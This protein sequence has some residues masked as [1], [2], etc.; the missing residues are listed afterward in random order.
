VTVDPTAL[1]TARLAL[2]TIAAT[3]PM[4]AGA[5]DTTLTRRTAVSDRYEPRTRCHKHAGD[6]DLD[7]DCGNC[8]TAQTNHDRWE[9]HQAARDAELR[10]ERQD[11]DSTERY[12]ALPS[13]RPPADLDVV[14]VRT[15][16]LQTV[17]TSVLL[18]RSDLAP[19]L[20]R[21]GTT[22]GTPP[23]RVTVSSIYS[24]TR[25]LAD[26]LDHTGGTTAA[27]IGTELRPAVERVHQVLGIDPDSAWRPMGTSR[28]P[29]CRQRAL[30]RWTDSP[31]R[32]AWT[33]ECR[34]P[35]CECAGATCPCGRD[36]ARSGSR[37][38]WQA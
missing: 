11:R 6:P 38:L 34:N 28:C 7:D 24:A 19:W 31:D 26:A 33:R 12:R 4:L 37:H 21:L 15:N 14:D 5:A 30:Y 35:E 17:H 10:A 32:R 25:W 27:A 29:A 1:Q 3:W 8:A 18:A 9:N 13:T 23:R 22:L 36:G 20:G 16:V 2:A